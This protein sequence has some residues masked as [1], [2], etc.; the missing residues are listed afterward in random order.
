MA[1]FPRSLLPDG[2]YH[3]MARGVARTAIFRDED[4]RLLFLRLMLNIVERWDWNFHALCL[5]GNH[6]H[7][8][9]DASRAALSAG[10]HRLNGIYARGFND[11]YHRSGH[12]FGDR[13]AC[14]IVEDEAYL[15]E[16][17]TYVV[18]NPVRAGLCSRAE[19]WPWS[20][21]RYGFEAC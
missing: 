19:D 7:L 3:A 4:D 1:R 17:C 20:R 18:N 5:M 8:V 14:R 10:M 13:F 9:L 11:R 12:L 15:H 16:L 21:S 6:Y 2:T